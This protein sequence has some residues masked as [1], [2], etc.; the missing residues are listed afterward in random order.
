MPLP[1]HS[2]FWNS[3]GDVRWTTWF[4]SGVAIY[5]ALSFFF[6]RY[7]HLLHKRKLTAALAHSS[8]RGGGAERPENSLAAFRNAIQLGCQLLELDVHLTSDGKVV[9]IHDANLRRLTGVDVDIR[10]V[11]YSNLPTLRKNLE[12]PMPFHLAGQHLTW[13]GEEKIPLLSEV[14]KEFPN[15]CINLDVKYFDQR[16]IHEVERVIVE[17]KMEKSHLGRIQQQNLQ[18]FIST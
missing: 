6:F 10:K 3:D 16:L 14:L 13:P 18:L 7:P 4:L 11:A 1:I 15:A 2:F 5:G 12:L 8:H 17:N 9:V